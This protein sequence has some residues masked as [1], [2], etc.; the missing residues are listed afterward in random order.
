[1]HFKRLLW[2]QSEECVERGKGKNGKETTVD[3]YMKEDSILDQG[4]GGT[5]REKWMDSKDT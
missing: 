5:V 3:I 1:M 4:G 2:L